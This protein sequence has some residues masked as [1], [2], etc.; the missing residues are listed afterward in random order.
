MKQNTI[1]GLLAA[2]LSSVVTAGTPVL[3]PRASST[4]TPITITGNGK[5]LPQLSSQDKSTDVL[6]QHFIKVASDSTSAASTISL[7]SDLP[8]LL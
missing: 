3:A 6:I 2:A 4:V 5:V 8:I 7:V 1:Y